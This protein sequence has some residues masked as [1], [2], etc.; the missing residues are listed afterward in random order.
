MDLSDLV[1]EAPSESQG[2]TAGK[3]LDS[4]DI[5]PFV[6]DPDKDE[7]AYDESNGKKKKYYYCAVDQ[8]TQGMTVTTN[9]RRHLVKKHW[10]HVVRIIGVNTS[11]FRHDLFR[12]ALV[13][14]IVVQSLPLS[15]VESNVFQEFCGSLYPGRLPDDILPKSHNT[16]RSWIQQKYEKKLGDVRELLRTAITRIHLSLDVWTTP[17]NYSVLAIIAHFVCKEKRRRTILLRLI[18][19]EGHAGVVQFQSL[20]PV[21]EEFDIVHR[22]GAIMGDNAG[23]NDT[24][25]RAMS[26][27]LKVKFP[28]QQEWIASQQRV[29]CFGHILN[30]VVQAYMFPKEADQEGIESYDAEIEQEIS[31][32]PASD[33]RRIRESQHRL[34]A[35]IGVLGNLHN[36]VVHIRSSPQRTEEFTRASGKRIPLDNCTRWNSWYK[37]LHTVFSDEEDPDF[38]ISCI[39]R[40]C[41]KYV[42]DL[43]EDAL[44]IGDWND[45]R[46]MYKHLEC[47]ADATADT[48]GR[49]ST[50]SAGMKCFDICSQL[51]DE[52]LKV[53]T[54]IEQGMQR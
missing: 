38:M 50:L 53:R 44:S 37:M 4:F 28:F 26:N 15:I 42:D 8:C 41:S 49:S 31:E 13:K 51:V 16:V 14:L 33:E 9:F 12:D 27:H 30:L 17:N 24:L 43:S 34:R 5:K 21:L 54:T 32:D 48:E 40:Y 45:L 29:R 3:L 22:I 46:T 10:D 2:L 18:G 25:C 35:V 36:I 11:L 52:F 20:L 7:P 6:R 47:F 23:T 19:I 39:N 1:S